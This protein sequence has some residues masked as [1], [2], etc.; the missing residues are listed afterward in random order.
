MRN[1]RAQV[2]QSKGITDGFY[3]YLAYMGFDADSGPWKVIAVGEYEMDE[4]IVK[5]AGRERIEAELVFNAIVTFAEERERDILR[6][7]V[8]LS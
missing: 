6:Q 2:V 1:P 4:R 7:E 5:F 8:G 3:I